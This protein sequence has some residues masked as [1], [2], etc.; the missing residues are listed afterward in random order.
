MKKWLALILCAALTL[1]AVLIALTL[2]TLALTAMSPAVIAVSA[3]LAALLA[4]AL[5][6]LSIIVLSRVLLKS[7]GCN[8]VI[9]SHVF[10]SSTYF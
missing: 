3:D 10:L 1:L 2:L 4:V 6:G 7:C 9:I 8:G 5:P